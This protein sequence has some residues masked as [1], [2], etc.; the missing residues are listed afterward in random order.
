MKPRDDDSKDSPGLTAAQFAELKEFAKTFL[1]I[2]AIGSIKAISK[3]E[4]HKNVWLLDAAGFSQPQI[5]L[6]LSVD[7]ATVSRILTGKLKKKY[8]EVSEE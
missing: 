1:K 6:I 5:A 8:A 3:G 4:M 2:T 7:Q